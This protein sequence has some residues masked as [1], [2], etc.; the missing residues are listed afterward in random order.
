MN[1][2]GRLRQMWRGREIGYGDPM[3]RRDWRRAAGITAIPLLLALFT[4]PAYAVT[5]IGSDDGVSLAG[6]VGPGQP[7]SAALAAPG[8]CNDP[9]YSLLAGKW[10]QP[11]D[12]R[13]QSSSTPGDM[14]ASNVLKV[15]KRSF[16][17]ITGARNDCGL[18][19]TVSATSQYLG[20]TSD[21]PSVTRRARCSPPDGQNIV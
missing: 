3:Q 2:V 21:K 12:W 4:S 10:K 20:T 19:D 1:Q 7:V 18:A 8:P 11:L 16:N 6:M 13:Y 14:S 9:A 15:I 5:P 17:N